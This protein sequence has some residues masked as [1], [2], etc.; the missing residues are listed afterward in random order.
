MGKF[1]DGIMEELKEHI[2][3]IKKEIENCIKKP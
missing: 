1:T 3:E 2:K